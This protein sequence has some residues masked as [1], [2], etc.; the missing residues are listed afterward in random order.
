[1]K[2]LTLLLLTIFAL[3][4]ICYAEDWTAEHDEMKFLWSTWKDTHS[5]SYPEAEESYRLNVFVQNWNKILA[6]NAQN[7]TFTLGLNHFSDLTGDEWKAQYGGGH[8][9]LNIT[10]DNTE[11]QGEDKRFLRSTT[12]SLP[13][14]FDWRKKGAVGQ[15]KN[16]KSCRGCWS[17]AA[18]AGLEALHFIKTGSLESFSE[19][20][21]LDCDKSAHG[22]SS[23]NMLTALGY[24]ASNGI[25][26]ESNY[27]FIEKVGSCKYS[28]SR[29]TR[30][31]KGRASVPA[32]NANALMS[33]I[34]NQPVLVAIGAYQSVFQHYKSGVISAGCGATT[35][36][37][38][39]AV[40]FTTV[41]G[42]QSIIIKN[43]WGTGW[44]EN[45][46]AYISASGSA[47]GGKG[48]CGILSLA[49]YPTA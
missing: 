17:F 28:S 25:E 46:Y 10:E 33:A 36:H 14:S 38:V 2:R 41:N 32:N 18:A 40:G 23:G 44:G 42:I 47:N 35:D 6:H 31:N 11:A 30:V 45:G 4:A 13:S 29:A 8:L 15:V 27:P 26:L 5:K 22:C 37:A 20:Q 9:P 21:L 24:T 34:V 19:Q 48:V 49:G 43:S 12:S 1:M 3:T 39:L 16:Q 7:S